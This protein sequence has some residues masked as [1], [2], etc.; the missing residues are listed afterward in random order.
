MP[1]YQSWQQVAGYF[2]G[3]GAIVTSD[4]S[5]QPFKLGLSL[6]FTD[7][8]LDQITNIK[9]FLNGEGVRTSNI[10]KTS[11]G[12]AYIVVV[13][14]FN[15]LRKSLTCMLP[16]LCKKA[17]E[18]Q[19]ALDYYGGRLTG[20][21]FMAILRQEVEAGRRERHV[22]K[23]PIDV[24]YTWPEGHRMMEERRKIKFR[25]VFGK[26]RA[27]VTPEDFET[28][29]NEFFTQGK[30]LHELVRKYP[31]YGRET[32]RRVLGGGRGYVGVKGLGRVETTDSR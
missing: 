1:E 27:K 9:N 22:R 8:S 15:S 10:L 13:S 23:T 31:Q 26:F 19:A 16:F 29:R 30:P 11:A 14:E 17:I 6:I 32:I 4:I 21:E 3:D 25:D 12:T 7:L 20:N 18:A 2:D 28:I 24:P 5:N